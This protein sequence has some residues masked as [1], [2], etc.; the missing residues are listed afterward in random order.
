MRSV[1]VSLCITGMCHSAC[2]LCFKPNVFHLHA[3]LVPSSCIR[4]HRFGLPAYRYAVSFAYLLSSL[5]RLLHYLRSL[6]RAWI[7]RFA[8]RLL[9]LT[10]GSLR[11]LARF[12]SSPASCSQ[13]LHPFA[14]SRR[15]LYLTARFVPPHALSLHPLCPSARFV[16]PTALSH[17]PL[18]PSARF[19]ST[20]AL[21][22][23][24][25]AYIAVSVGTMLNS[26]AT[27]TTPYV[28][29]SVLRRV[30]LC[31]M[32]FG[33]CVLWLQHLSIP[34]LAIDRLCTVSKYQSLSL[35]YHVQANCYLL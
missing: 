1:G 11:M 14:Q 2:Q 9:T 34:N 21:S 3:D 6:A 33:L 23:H 16:S 18:R 27:M 15:P 25:L 17:R 22:R 24:P 29:A 31:R 19:V 8:S 26:V 5:T 4:Q 10:G 20:T 32:C 28:G 30:R 12:V 7:C 35:F 13:V